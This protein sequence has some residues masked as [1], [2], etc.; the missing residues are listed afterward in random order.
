[1]HI[2]TLDI[3]YLPAQAS[4]DFDFGNV[5]RALPD[6]LLDTNIGP[7]QRLERTTSAWGGQRGTT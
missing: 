7:G 6:T 1:M 5:A 2:C 4:R 3:I